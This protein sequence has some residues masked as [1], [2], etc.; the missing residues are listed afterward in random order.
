MNHN[1]CDMDIIKAIFLPKENI[2]HNY[3]ANKKNAYFLE[4]IID[5]DNYEKKTIV[6]N[7][8]P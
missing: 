5:Y 2:V 1:V 8:L 6:I 4:H 7:S 3:Y